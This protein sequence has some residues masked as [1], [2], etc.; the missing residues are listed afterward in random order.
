MT[1]VDSSAWIESFR[2][3]GS[4]THLRVRELLTLTNEIAICEAIQMEVFAGV[5]D[6]QHLVHLRG[7]LSGA[8]IIPI[9]P[10][11]YYD[12][13]IL[14]RRCRQN[15]ITIRSQIDCLIAAVA[16]RAQIPIL[17]HDRDFTTLARHTDLTID[18]ASL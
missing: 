2:R 8:T 15:G 6:D 16:I 4:P 13:A 3:T 18:P 11:D 10:S 17:H 1:L 14:Y 5:R 9:Q 12:A 7:V